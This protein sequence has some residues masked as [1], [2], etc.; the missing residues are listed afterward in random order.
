MRRRQLPRI[1]LVLGGGG[2]KGAFQAGAVACLYSEFGLR[3]DTIAGTSVGALAATLL[4]H[5][6]TRD[7]QREAADRLVSI[8]RSLRAESDM[9]VPRRWL[10]DVPARTRADLAAIAAGRASAGAVLGIARSARGLRRAVADFRADGASAYSLE[11][12]EALVRKHVDPGI[13]RDGIA[14]LRISVVSVETGELRWAGDDGTLYEAD[15]LTPAQGGRVGLV[16]ALLASVAFVPAFPARS[17]AGGSYVDGGFR[18]V[19]PVRGALATGAQVVVA[20]ACAGTGM[21]LVRPSAGATLLRTTLR[22]Y[23]ATMAEVGRRDV[24][25]LDR[26]R[27][28][29]LEPRVWVHDFLA[30]DPGRIAI[31][32]DQGWMSA[33]E[34]LDAIGGMDG[35]TASLHRG[36]PPAAD[37]DALTATSALTDAVVEL[38]TQAWHLEERLAVGSPPAERRA[39]LEGLRIRK[40]LLRPA[41]AVRAALPGPRP[42]GMAGWAAGFDAHRDPLVVPDPWAGLSSIHG[43][44]VQAVDAAGYVPPTFRLRARPSG[45]EWVVAG[46]IR[47]PVVEGVL[48]AGQHVGTPGDGAA[49]DGLV[50]VGDAIAELVPE[51]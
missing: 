3:P 13:V 9:Y 33:A 29:L 7:E 42:T 36:R 28:V 23:G 43:A 50:E 18:S 41:V 27:G 21:G 44:H 20:V 12:V 25:D 37:P 1:G 32:L 17:M 11:P 6:R 19:L 14:T 4:A 48:V 8:W 2:S 35:L 16:D 38:R 49:G 40:W 5:A 34:Q 15:A 39:A 24:G 30:V 31:S 10:A 45:R 51:A 26:V 47:H 46:G 22:A